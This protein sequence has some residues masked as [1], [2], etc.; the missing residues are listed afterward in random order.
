MSSSDVEMV[1]SSHSES[2]PEGLQ[3][4]RVAA[5]VAAACKRGPK[6]LKVKGKQYVWKQHEDNQRAFITPSVIWQ[7]GDE[8]KKI[9]SGHRRKF[10]RCGLCLNIK[11]LIINDNFT[12]GLRYLK[13][14]Y[15][16]DKYR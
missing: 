14:K 4:V 10:W 15:K 1:D 12:S 3:H 2:E 6:R 16:I 8:Y 11:I 5:D 9:G 13:K 7:L